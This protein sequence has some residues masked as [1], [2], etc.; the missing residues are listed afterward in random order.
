M[1]IDLLIILLNGLGISF[2]CESRLLLSVIAGRQ[3]SD[4]ET[5]KIDYSKS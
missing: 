1:A 3:R 5:V 4:D 2:K